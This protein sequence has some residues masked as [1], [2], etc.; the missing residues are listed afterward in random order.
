MY[1]MTLQTTYKVHSNCTDVTLCVCV[2]LQ[3]TKH[4]HQST[5]IRKPDA[6]FVHTNNKTRSVQPTYTSVSSV[7]HEKLWVKLI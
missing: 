3:Q 4:S 1:Q 7:S 5:E 6:L 2:I